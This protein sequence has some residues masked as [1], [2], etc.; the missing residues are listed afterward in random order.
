MYGSIKLTYYYRRQLYI[1]LQRILRLTNSLVLLTEYY[2]KS[3][4]ENVVITFKCDEQYNGISATRHPVDFQVYGA[5]CETGVDNLVDT[6]GSD[7]C[8]RRIKPVETL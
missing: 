8:R 6:S 7:M 4:P 2:V 1:S 3:M 5:P